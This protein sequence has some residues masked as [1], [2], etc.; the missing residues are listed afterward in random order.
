LSAGDAQWTAYWIKFL[1]LDF[2]VSIG[3]APLAWLFPA[4][5]MGPLHDFPNFWWPLAYHGTVGT[6]WWYVVGRF[7]AARALFRKR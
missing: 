3:V 5:S 7:I 4:S 1:A 2:P 6:L